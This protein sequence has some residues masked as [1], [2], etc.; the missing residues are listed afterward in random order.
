MHTDAALKQPAD[1]NFELFRTTPKTDDPPL[2]AIHIVDV[3]SLLQQRHDPPATETEIGL[4]QQQKPH[5]VGYNYTLKSDNRLLNKRKLI[6]L[7]EPTNR[8]AGNLQDALSKCVRSLTDFK[9]NWT[10]LHWQL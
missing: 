4:G 7:S 1:G 10:I 6:F 2:P 5:K 8:Y 9:T 3:A